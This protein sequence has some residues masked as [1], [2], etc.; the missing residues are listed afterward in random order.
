M[1]DET[2]GKVMVISK[3][4]PSIT[5]KRGMQGNYGWDI[6]M[7]A[8]TLAEAM[9]EAAICDQ[10]LRKQYGEVQIAERPTRW[11]RRQEND[12]PDL[13]H[14]IIAEMDEGPEK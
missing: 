3:Q 12:K 2:A 4:Q 9:K 11:A 5:L 8:P 6:S 14:I 1:V 10:E 7:P 13:D